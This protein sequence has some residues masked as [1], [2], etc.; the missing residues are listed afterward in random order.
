MA[1]LAA[2]GCGIVAVVFV[3]DK[4]CKPRGSLQYAGS[5]QNIHVHNTSIISHASS[6]TAHRHCLQSLQNT[7][8]GET[9]T[10][11]GFDPML[12]SPY[13]VSVLAALFPNVTTLTWEE[14]WGES[15]WVETPK[16]VSMSL[17]ESAAVWPRLC[18][19]KAGSIVGG[20]WLLEQEQAPTFEEMRDTL[21]PV[22]VSMQ[23]SRRFLKLSLGDP[24][25][26]VSTK[27]VSEMVRDA[28]KRLRVEWEGW[29]VSGMEQVVTLEPA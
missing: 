27:A 1:S 16:L 17:C 12:L 10:E 8:F 3:H 19:I 9:V 15:T 4:K 2:F 26:Y 6:R 13:A 28:W 20:G 23:A 18:S 24:N 22:M 29:R 14:G 5:T 7:R 25:E 11:L 21:L